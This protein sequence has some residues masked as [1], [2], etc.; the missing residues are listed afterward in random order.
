M[1]FRND[2]ESFHLRMSRIHNNFNI[3]YFLSALLYGTKQDL[4]DAYYESGFLDPAKRDVYNRSS[5][6]KFRDLYELS[7]RRLELTGDKTEIIRGN[8]YLQELEKAR[9]LRKQ[10]KT[11][12]K[13]AIN[14]IDT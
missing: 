8:Y 9:K 4:R 12:R 1:I 14:K 13:Y 7:V 2:L 5:V 11:E 10:T 6:A 3:S